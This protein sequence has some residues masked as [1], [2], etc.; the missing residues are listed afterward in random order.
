MINTTHFKEVTYYISV[1]NNLSVKVKLQPGIFF[2][3]IQHGYMCV[4]FLFFK[5]LQDVT[6]A[7]SETIRI[8]VLL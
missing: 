6:V 7:P 4:A 8:K 3:T 5:L 1:H 2:P